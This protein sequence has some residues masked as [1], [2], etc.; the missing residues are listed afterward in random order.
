M[1]ISPDEATVN[2]CAPEP[3]LLGEPLDEAFT[4]YARAGA[5]LA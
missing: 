2:A 3:P 1:A 4:R 5:D